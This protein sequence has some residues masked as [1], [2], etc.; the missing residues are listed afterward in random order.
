VSIRKSTYKD[1]VIEFLY[2][3]IIK[4]KL[5][6]GDR[7]SETW[8]AEKLE[9]SR[10]PIREAL[11]QLSREGL[12]EYRP[13]VGN[14]IS[15][16]SSK[17]IFDTYVTRGVLEGFAASTAAESFEENDFVKLEELIAKMVDSAKQHK[18]MNLSYYDKQFHE[19]IFQKSKNFQ[20]IEFVKILSVLLHVIFCKYWTKVYDPEQIQSRHQFIVDSI[21]QK[22]KQLIEACIRRH[23][24]ETG[25]YMSQFGSDIKSR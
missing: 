12:I 2:D 18:H 10:A 24:Q 19:Y 23:Y 9:I 13:Q 7:V 11:R 5:N 14:Y 15:A 25:K 1:Q 21:R 6:P 4:G 16:L 22:D 3:T 20:L 17:Q 8:L